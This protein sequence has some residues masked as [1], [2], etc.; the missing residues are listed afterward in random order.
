MAASPKELLE[1]GAEP[2][3]SQLLKGVSVGVKIHTWKKISDAM[4]KII[5]ANEVDQ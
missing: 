2:M 1:E 4:I 5:E 3:I